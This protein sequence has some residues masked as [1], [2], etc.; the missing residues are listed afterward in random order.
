MTR[1]SSGAVKP[2]VRCGATDRNPSGKCRACKREGERRRRGPVRSRERRPAY[3]KLPLAQQLA[4]AD[5]LLVSLGYAPVGAQAAAP[6]PRSHP[7][8]VSP[9]N[10][11]EELRQLC[12]SADMAR[13]A[14]EPAPAQHPTGR[15]LDVR[16]GLWRALE[17]VTLQ[18]HVLVY[19]EGQPVNVVGRGELLAWA[20]KHAPAL[21]AELGRHEAR[22]GWITTLRTS[23]SWTAGSFALGQLRV[24][25]P[26]RAP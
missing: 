14:P 4:R 6:S 19:A 21:A 25:A 22:P 8:T 13:P 9:R 5:A 26:P 24:V 2:C 10:L 12:D 23:V 20:R 15:A 17:A 16:L 1:P 7:G 18:D 11:R 3:P